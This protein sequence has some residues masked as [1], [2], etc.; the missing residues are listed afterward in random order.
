MASKLKL[1]L[2]LTHKCIMSFPQ[3]DALKKKLQA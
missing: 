2:D 3:E 1:E